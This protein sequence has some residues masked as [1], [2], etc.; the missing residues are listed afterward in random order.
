[1]SIETSAAYRVLIVL[2]SSPRMA[3]LLFCSSRRRR[4]AELCYED[5][6]VCIYK[7]DGFASA[8]ALR[9]RI[10]ERLVRGAALENFHQDMRDDQMHF[11]GTR[12]SSRGSNARD[13]NHFHDQQEGGDLLV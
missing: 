4:W 3:S 8:L 2:F 11:F 10:K 6:Y 5:I 1:M 7:T 13:P 9:S 12:E